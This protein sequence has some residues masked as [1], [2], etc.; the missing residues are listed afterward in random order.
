MSILPV[1]QQGSDRAV[2]ISNDAL[3][4]FY[5]SDYSVLGLLVANLDGARQ[6]LA[7][8]KFAV[9]DKSD[10]L[11]VNIDRAAQMREITTLLDQNGIN[12]GLS[13][14]VDQVYQ[15]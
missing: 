6:V 1:L 14:I 12:C 3:P 7:D 11:E 2:C 4:V 5:M 15:G 13:D 10:H 9:T 8:H